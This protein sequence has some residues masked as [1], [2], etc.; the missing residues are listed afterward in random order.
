M[1]KAQKAAWSRI[2]WRSSSTDTIFSS[3]GAGALLIPRLGFPFRA[4]SSSKGAAEQNAWVGYFR[5]KTSQKGAIEHALI[6]V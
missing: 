6:K 4:G 1:V 5:G 2:G 3:W